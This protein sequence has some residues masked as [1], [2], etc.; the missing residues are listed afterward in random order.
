MRMGVRAL[1]LTM[2]RNVLFVVPALLAL[3]SA[4]GARG[5][6]AAQPASD[7]LGVLIAG[8]MLWQVYRR[9]PVGASAPAGGE[10]NSEEQRP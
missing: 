9:Y 2:A 5:A 1:L 10:T 3:S 4:Y 7:L 6:F 8:G